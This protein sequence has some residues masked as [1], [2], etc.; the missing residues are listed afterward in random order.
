MPKP[1]AIP[2][3]TAADQLLSIWIGEWAALNLIILSGWSDSM[4]CVSLF[5]GLLMLGIV[6][7]T[8][9]MPKV[10]R[11]ILFFDFCLIFFH[12]FKINIW[13]TKTI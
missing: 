8:K 12:F 7:K 6:N 2:A 9:K 4:A 11:I 5:I 1:V 13:F 3:I 10:N